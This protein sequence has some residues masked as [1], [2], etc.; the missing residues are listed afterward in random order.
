MH[1]YT[2]YMYSIW[3]YFFIY[4]MYAYSD[5]F[6]WVHVVHQQFNMV[7]M[8]LTEHI[9]YICFPDTLWPFAYAYTVC[10]VFVL[11]RPCRQDLRAD[12][13]TRG[14]SRRSRENTL[15]PGCCV[16]CLVRTGA[17]RAPDDNDRVASAVCSSPLSQRFSGA[18]NIYI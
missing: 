7:S 3:I 18:L 8:C 13:C 11:E 17:E 1:T 4:S 14:S 9:Y 2:V 16:F 5:Q 6:H 15:P 10:F 12:D